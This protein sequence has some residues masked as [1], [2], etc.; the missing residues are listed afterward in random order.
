MICS[1]FWT[2]AADLVICNCVS[3]VCWTRIVCWIAC[4][5]SGLSVI[6]FGCTL[7]EWVTLPSEFPHTGWWK[8]ECHS[9]GQFN[10]DNGDDPICFVIGFYHRTQSTLWL[11]P[12]TTPVGRSQIF[13]YDSSAVRDMLES[14]QRIIEILLDSCGQWRYNQ[15]VWLAFLKLKSLCAELNTL[16]VHY[17]NMAASI[18]TCRQCMRPGRRKTRKPFLYLIG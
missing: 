12:I 8:E 16:S 10:L 15:A 1:R 13:N 4:D 3:C 11:T 2:P 18:L 17:T 5:L 6:F 14:S 7:W 9:A